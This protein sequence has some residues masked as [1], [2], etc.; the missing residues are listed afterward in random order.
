MRNK[1]L[2]SGLLAFALL[3]SAFGSVSAKSVPQE[4]KSIPAP[5][6]TPISGDQNFTHEIV[7]ILDLPGTTPLADEMPVPVG[8]SKGEKQFEG[9]GLKVSGFDYGKARVCFPLSSYNQGWGGKVAK[10]TGSKWEL[11]TT[12]ISTPE[13]SSYAL[14]CS[15]IS[16][17][18]TYA[19]LAWVVDSSKLPTAAKPTCDFTVDW[20]ELVDATPPVNHGDYLTTYISKM[21]IY[22]TAN[23][24][25]KGLTL[26][27]NKSVPSGE[28]T[29]DGSASGSLSSTDP[30]EYILGP[31]TPVLASIYYSVTSEEYLLDFGFC[32]TT[33]PNGDYME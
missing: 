14:A 1:N 6:I 7:A 3:L 4:D 23:L 16:S 26:S 32:T 19:L 24:I 17:N 21:K 27:V 13:D 10:W 20:V 33:A 30:N 31:F 18:G 22:S 8:F 5:T 15:D 29:W 11:L 2:I 12:T 9:V 25:G 28:Y